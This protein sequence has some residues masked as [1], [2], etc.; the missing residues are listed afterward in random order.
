MHKSLIPLKNL[1]PMLTYSMKP[2]LKTSLN[3]PQLDKMLMLPLVNGIPMLMIII[4]MLYPFKEWE[5]ELLKE[6]LE[7]NYFNQLTDLNNIWKI[8][9]NT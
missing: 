7:I 5:P 3:L 1:K 6:M 2:P 4:E 8:Q 9:L